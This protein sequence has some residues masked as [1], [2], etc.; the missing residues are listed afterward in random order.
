MFQRS[1]WTSLFISLLAMLFCFQTDVSA[2]GDPVPVAELTAAPALTKITLINTPGFDDEFNHYAWSVAVFNEKLYVGT[3]NMEDDYGDISHGAKVY[4]YLDDGSQWENVVE[5]GLGDISNFGIRMLIPFMGENGTEALY[6]T[7]MNVNGLEVWRSETGDFGDWQRVVGGDSQYPNG[8][9]RAFNQSGRAMAVYEIDGKKW[10]YLGAMAVGGGQIWR[11]ADGFIWQKVTDARRL[12]LKGMPLA[13]ATMCVYQD[14]PGKPAALFVGTWGVLGFN[15]IKTY[16]GVN[17]QK[18]ATG[19][20]GNLLNEGI[21]KMIPFQGRLW[22]LTINYVQGFDV[23]AS[24]TGV[25]SGN[26]DWQKVA[27]KG[28]T[29]PGNVYAW[30]GAVYTHASGEKRL[31]IGTNNPYN[32]FYLY[33]VTEDFRWAAEVGG[34]EGNYPNGLGDPYLFALRTLAVY[35]GKLIMGSAANIRPARVWMAE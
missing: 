10:L 18:V 4:R 16:D 20:L 33:S 28:F 2:T 23:Y 8:F 1:A 27:T 32:A 22:L 5:N 3:W 31:Y 9:G 14:D 35:Q 30:D 7:T 6:G 21:T 26:A 11:T 24:G 12:G 29:D 34:T 17:F 25:I 13:M 19:G 15:V